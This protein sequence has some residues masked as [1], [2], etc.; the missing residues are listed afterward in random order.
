MS[1]VRGADRWQV[2]LLPPSV[3]DYVAAESAVR[4]I[5]AFVEG[6]NL[7]DLHFTH[8]DAA[9][10]GRPAYDP[11]D[12]LKLY[13]YGYLNRLRSSRRLEAECRRNL[14]VM[15]L[16]R[17]LR[18]DFKTIADFRKDN[19]ATF[20]PLFRQFNLICRKL[21]LFGAELVAI[22]GSKFKAVN[23][24]RQN[25]NAKRLK[26]L[27]E[28]IDQRI[29]GYL[30]KLDEQDEQVEGV[31][32]KPTRQELEDSIAQL[33]Q[34]RGRYDQLL[35]DLTA[36]GQSEVSLVDSDSRAMPKVGV[37]YNVQVAVDAQHHLIVEPEVVQS[38]SDLGQLSSMALAAKD[39]LGV[40]RLQAVADA[41]Y[42]EADQ[43][44][45]CEKAGIETYV[46]DKGQR[47]GQTNAGQRVFSKERFRYDPVSDAY[48]CPAGQRLSRGYEHRYRGKDVVRY[49]N[50]RACRECSLKGQCTHSL[51]RMISRRKNEAVVE[52][53]K[54]RMVARPE[55]ARRRKSI[56]EH[57]F[58]SLRNWGHDRFLM[59][60]LENVRAEFSLSALAY[61]LRQVLN[62]LDV[63]TLLEKL[64]ETQPATA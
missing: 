30:A 37:G 27:L 44:E 9:Q 61:N 62:L 3:E 6:L 45:A 33:K 50:G 35:S 24:P 40:E 38:A 55:M 36:A 63:P 47:S 53:Q 29:D 11:A 15:W 14:E 42:N 31:A 48:Y 4:F 18:P 8:A 12:L 26:D 28:T 64:S 17:G 56:V 54:Q 49:Y 10:T 52:R 2:Q 51:M 21:N 46:A 39:A 20:K 5:D 19:R 58:G 1:Y 41:G 60:G 59:R 57:V 22:D 25:Y 43:L 23:H 34:R 7:K 13:L 32:G 16:V